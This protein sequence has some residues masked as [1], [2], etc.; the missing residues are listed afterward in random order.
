MLNIMRICTRVTNLVS[1]AVKASLGDLAK[2]SPK[3]VRLH[4]GSKRMFPG[5]R[6][7]KPC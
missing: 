1:M 4:M 7:D 6:I 2:L 5:R 3:E